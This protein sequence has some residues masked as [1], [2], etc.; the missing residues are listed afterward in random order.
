MTTLTEIA[1]NYLLHTPEDFE[2]WLQAHEADQNCSLVLSALLAGHD[3]ERWARDH[4]SP[5]LLTKR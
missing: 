5:E 3:L 2:A 1:D 4:A